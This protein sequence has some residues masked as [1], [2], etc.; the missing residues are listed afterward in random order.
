MVKN[1]ATLLDLTTFMF[2]GVLFIFDPLLELIWV[3]TP[4][5]HSTMKTPALGLN[6]QLV[7]VFVL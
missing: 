4:A 7:D 5:A 1:N 6:L 3:P 2:L